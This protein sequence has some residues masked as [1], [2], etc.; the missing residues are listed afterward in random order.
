MVIDRILHHNIYLK[1]QIFH[2]FSAF[3]PILYCS[4]MQLY[5]ILA[6]IIFPGIMNSY[7]ILCEKKNYKKIYLQKK[8]K[9]TSLYWLKKLLY[10]H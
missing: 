5:L 3:N 4:Y 9:K 8:L 2:L 7:F 6:L 1:Y 10:I